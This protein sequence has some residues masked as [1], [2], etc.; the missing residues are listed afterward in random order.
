M[1]R[2]VLPACKAVRN[3]S[4]TSLGVFSSVRYVEESFNSGVAS[5]SPASG[6]LA[7]G[8]CEAPQAGHTVQSDGSR[9]PQATHATRGATDGPMPESTKPHASHASEPGGTGAWQRGQGVAFVVAG[10]PHRGHR[11]TLAGIVALQVGH[12]TSAGPTF[13]SAAMIRSASDGSR[14]SMTASSAFVAAFSAATLLYPASKRAIAFAVVMPGTFVNS[15]SDS[16]MWSGVTP[17]VTERPS[18]SFHS[19]TYS[20][21]TS[22]S[23]NTKLRDRVSRAMKAAWGARVAANSL[24]V[25]TTVAMKSST[26]RSISF[27]ICCTRR[28]ISRA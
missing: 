19:T 9:A 15:R 27:R 22:L 11:R 5:A 21:P 20:D 24:F 25:L 4:Y 18:T 12:S 14:P 1:K 13:D 6:R 7:P 26:S 17:I 2:P 16:D 23:V 28:M 10:S 8:V 3:R